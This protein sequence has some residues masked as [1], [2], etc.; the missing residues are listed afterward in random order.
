MRVVQAFTR[1]QTQ[2]PATSA[3]SASA[4]AQSNQQTVVLSGLYF[5]FV[6]LLSTV[7]LAVVLGYGG[8]LYFQGARDDRDALRLHALRAELLRPRAGSSRSCTGRSSRRPPRW[9]RSPSS[10]TRSPRCVDRPGARELAQIGRRRPLRGRPLHLRPRRRGAARDRPRRRRRDDR[11]PRRPH[12][13]RQVDDREAARALLRPDARRGSR[14]TA[15]TSATSRQASLRRQLGVVPQEGFLF[16]GT[17]RENIAFGRPD[18]TASEIVA[19]AAGRR[20]ARLHRPARG[21]LRDRA[22]RARLA[23]LARPAPAGRVRAGAAR[24]PAHPRPRRGDLVGRHRHRAPDR[25]RAARRSSPAG[26]RS[27]S[28]TASRRSATPT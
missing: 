16:A 5:P 25:A 24:R 10:S 19:A 9:T 20:R 7:A 18:A 4:T 26:R 28:R 13:R 6:D 21:R 22:R 8:H 12:R 23:A 11:R 15:P 17:V 14:S 1:E 27:S 3:R 2:H